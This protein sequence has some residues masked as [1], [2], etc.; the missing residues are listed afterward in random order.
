MPMIP[1]PHDRPSRP[2]IVD[3]SALDSHNLYRIRSMSHQ[4]LQRRIWKIRKPEKLESF[5]KV[6]TLMKCGFGMDVHFGVLQSGKVSGS[7]VNNESFFC[8]SGLLELNLTCAL[9]RQHLN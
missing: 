3:E 8:S 4:A 9:H 6:S 2:V 7:I 1:L 5:I